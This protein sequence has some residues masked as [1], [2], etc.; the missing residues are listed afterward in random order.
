M[1]LPTITTTKTERTR[2]AE[3]ALTAN[4][5]EFQYCFVDFLVEYL[6]DLSRMFRGDLTLML[7]LAVIGQS[8]I[9]AVRDAMTTGLA[10][11]EVA[12]LRSGVSASRVADLTSVPRQTVRRKLAQLRDKGWVEQYEDGTW[13]MTVSQGASNARQ[14]LKE[15]DRRALARVARMFADLES[16]VG[17]PS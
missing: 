9:R 7:V 5:V 15:A 14:D 2:Q 17:P 4:Y 1:R 12:T 16:I 11:A 6:E 8:R 3:D 13:G 10:P